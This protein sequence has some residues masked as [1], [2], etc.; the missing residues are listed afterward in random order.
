MESTDYP[1][2]A[3]RKSEPSPPTSLCQHLLPLESR[4]GPFPAIL[5]VMW[6]LDP[7]WLAHWPSFRGRRSFGEF[8][9]KLGGSTN[10]SEFCHFWGIDKLMFLSHYVLKQLIGRLLLCG[11]R[12]IMVNCLRNA[13]CWKV[14]PLSGTWCELSFCKHRC[15]SHGG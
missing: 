7:L 1:Y 8:Q 13:D 14:S 12:H 6:H 4:D 5:Q 15:Q 11:I 3:S 10:R 9:Q 2:F